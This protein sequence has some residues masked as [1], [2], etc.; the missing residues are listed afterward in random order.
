VSAGGGRGGGGE[1]G[2][3]EQGRAARLLIFLANDSTRRRRVDGRRATGVRGISGSLQV[4]PPQPACPPACLPACLPATLPP[5][6]CLT[7]FSP[8]L[9]GND[10]DFRARDMRVANPP[11]GEGSGEGG[12]EGARNHSIASNRHFYPRMPVASF[13]YPLTSKPPRVI[14]SLSPPPRRPCPFPFPPTR[15]A[16]LGSVSGSFFLTSAPRGG[17][18]FLHPAGRNL[19]DVRLARDR[20]G[21]R[22]R[23]GERGGTA[24]PPRANA[25]SSEMSWSVHLRISAVS[26][27]EFCTRVSVRARIY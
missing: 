26:A 18:S 16:S 6:L 12:S 13:P 2:E 24:P 20:P 1:G 22:L 17:R 4:P 5:F 15:A 14:L 21:S 10:N 3:G 7:P 27:A 8:C 19:A 25:R 9:R 23:R 11:C